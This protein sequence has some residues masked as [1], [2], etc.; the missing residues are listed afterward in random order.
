MLKLQIVRK[1]VHDLSSGYFEVFW[2]GKE[3]RQSFLEEVL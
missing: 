1:T 2:E 3:R